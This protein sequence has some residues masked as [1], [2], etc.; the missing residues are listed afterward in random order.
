MRKSLHQ[1]A[2]AVLTSTRPPC[3]RRGRQDPYHTD[4]QVFRSNILSRDLSPKYLA[5]LNYL[6]PEARQTGLS[7]TQS[8]QIAGQP[9][10][11]CAGY[12]L[13]AQCNSARAL[14]AFDSGSQCECCSADAWRISAIVCPPPALVSCSTP[15]LGQLA[16]NDSRDK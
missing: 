2:G 14:A 7:V 12:E 6:R 4:L 10:W 5:E 11:I 9:K 1:S 8:S 13:S 16:H 3:Q 15:L